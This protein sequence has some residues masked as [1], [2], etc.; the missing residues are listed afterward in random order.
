MTFRRC[1]GLLAALLY[2]LLAGCALHHTLPPGSLP[3]S[4]IELTR[5]PFYPQK[6]HQCGPAALAAALG[7][8]G[9][10]VRPENLAPEIY[11]PG[12]HGSLQLELIAAIRG[13]HRIPYRIDP[14]ISAI[15]AELQARRPVLVLQNL[16]LKSLP[17]YHYALIIGIQSAGRIVLRSG[18]TRRLVMDIDDFLDTWQRA[19]RW[20]L[21]ILRPGE[22]PAD[23]DPERYLQTVAAIEITGNARLAETGYRAL[24]RRFPH[25]SA[26][27]FGLA[28]TLYSQQRFHEAIPTYRQLLT[29]H[30]TMGEAANNL[31]ETYAAL[32]CY[33]KAL[34][35]LDRLVAASESSAA[36]PGFVTATRREIREKME[37]ARRLS[38]EPAAKDSR[39]QCA[40]LFDSA[41][42]VPGTRRPVGVGPRDAG[43]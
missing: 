34:T 16:G 30:P 24:L 7:A 26:A 21:V 8:A 37:K 19:D 36:P 9:V 33:H 29:L 35:V 25:Q 42:A 10:T 3:T 6:I 14:I 13:N 15:T 31:A 18:T 28:N 41:P 38:P 32:H 23:L 40:H 2:W 11:L 43:P 20:G 27:L 17:V 4:D 1:P 39:Q 22:L 5:T 12:R